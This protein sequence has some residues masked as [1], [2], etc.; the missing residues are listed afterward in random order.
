MGRVADRYW[1]KLPWDL[2]ARDDHFKNLE[3]ADVIKDAKTILAE[4][5]DIA[6][7]V[8]FSAFEAIVRDRVLNE[9]AAEANLVQHP[10]LVRAIASLKD[11]I[12]EGSFYNNVLELYKSVDHNLVEQI[13]QI[14]QYRNWVAHGR[15]PGKV[16]TNVTPRVAH[17]RMQEFLALIRRGSDASP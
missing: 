17:D 13:N 1:T 11:N 4:F 12:E 10:A 2:M 8:I 9:V 6:V 16:P 7:F 5:D 3:G 15:R 14:R